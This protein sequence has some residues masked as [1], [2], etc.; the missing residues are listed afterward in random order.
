MTLNTEDDKLNGR[1]APKE[2]GGGI[3]GCSPPKPNKTKTL[4]TEI[5][6]MRW[7]KTF[8]WFTLGP[9]SATKIG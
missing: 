5:L 3:P 1:I 7:Y 4:K 8:T 9:K 6:W 2:E